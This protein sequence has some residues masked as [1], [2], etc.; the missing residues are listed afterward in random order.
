MSEHLNAKTGQAVSSSHEFQ[1]DN[2]YQQ[3]AHLLSHHWEERLD[4]FELPCPLCKG[5]LR[6]QGA[7]R[8]PLYEFA[9]GEPGV[10]NPLNLL[11]ISFTC[12]QCGYNAEFDADLFN[13]AYLAELQGAKPEQVA[14]LAVRDFR[15]LVPLVGKERSE[16]LLD[17]AS[18]LAGVRSGEVIVLNVAP[19]ETAAEHLRDRLHHYRPGVGDP[20]P[21]HVLRHQSDD[22]GDAIVNV[23]AQ[24]R[25]QLLLVGWRGWTR[26]QQAVMGTVL[27]PVLNEAIC[28]VGVVHDRGLPTVRRILMATSGGTSAKV[29]SHIAYDLAKAFDAELHLLYVAAPNLPNAEA[30]GQAQIAKAIHEMKPDGNNSDVIIERRVV[31]GGDVVRTIVDESSSYDLL[32]LGASHRNNW[33]GKFGHDSVAAK[34]VRNSNPTAIVVSAR[35]SRIGSWLHRLFT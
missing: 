12:E 20:A 22:I 31:T 27:D 15:V 7:R 35:H 5:A 6:F 18:A 34:I 32:I 25:C 2:W 16:T 14:Q 21:V 28:D 10:V 8:N 24:Q 11:S 13:P 19:D 29:A 23:S 33:R 30:K 4:R 26:N 17:L 3:Q 1:G 9:E